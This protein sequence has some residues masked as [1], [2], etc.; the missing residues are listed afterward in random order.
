MVIN[1]RYSA[2]DY[3]SGRPV[4]LNLL[5]K[6]LKSVDLEGKYDI[7]VNVQGGGKSGQAGAIAHGIAKAIVELNPS[8]KKEL[9]LAGLITRDSR[10][11]ESKK[12]GRKKARKGDTYR[13][14]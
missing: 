14:R 13:K 4:W 3:F 5:Q 7:S 8:L 12:Y 1:D 10:V 9:K 11:K 6:P 2:Q